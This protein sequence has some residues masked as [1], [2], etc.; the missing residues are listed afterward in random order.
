MQKAKEKYS[1]EKVA[2]YYKQNKEV[3]KEKSEERYKTLSHKEKDKNKEYQRKKYQ[4]L[5]QYKKVALKN[6]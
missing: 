3:T 4:E 5:V 1:N 2:E 6:K